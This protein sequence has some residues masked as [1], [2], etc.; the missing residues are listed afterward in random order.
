[1]SGLWSCRFHSIPRKRKQAKLS[2]S[3]FSPTLEHQLQQWRTLR[4][5]SQSKPARKMICHSSRFP[6][7]ATPHNNRVYDAH[8]IW[9][10]K[11]KLRKSYNSV[12]SMLFLHKKNKINS[13]LYRRV[14]WRAVTRN[15]LKDKIIYEF[16]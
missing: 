10:E 3:R 1:M 13:S 5:L 12:R 4:S 2:V 15:N 11:L 8:I 6:L 16:R 9:L 14:V 7:G